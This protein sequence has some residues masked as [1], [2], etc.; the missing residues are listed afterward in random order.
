MGGRTTTAACLITRSTSFRSSIPSPTGSRRPAHSPVAPLLLLSPAP[1]RIVDA[2]E[3]ARVVV[4]GFRVLPVD[5]QRRLIVGDG[6]GKVAFSLPRYAPVHIGL[7]ERRVDGE[8]RVVV[9]DRR[10]EIARLGPVVAADEKDD[11]KRVVIV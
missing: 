10:I 4:D 9:G 6:P 3:R 7:R 8:R 5:A 11:G 1:A 2:L